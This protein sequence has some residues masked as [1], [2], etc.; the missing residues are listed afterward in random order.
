MDDSLEQMPEANHLHLPAEKE[1]LSLSELVERIPYRPQTI[2]NLMC[3]GILREGLHY[4]KP[5]QR[6]VVF[7]WSAMRRW[8]EDENR[9]HGLAIPLARGR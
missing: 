8:I 5:T 2:R 3:Q 6:K 9:Q 7:K 4:F 1:Y